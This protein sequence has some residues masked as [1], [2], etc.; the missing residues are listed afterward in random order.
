MASNQTDPNISLYV[1]IFSGNKS[2]SV[3]ETREAMQ[4]E[5]IIC[6]EFVAFVNCDYLLN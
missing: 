3:G 4:P 6:F 1:I 2:I 5:N